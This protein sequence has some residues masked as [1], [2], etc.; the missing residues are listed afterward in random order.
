MLCFFAVFILSAE[1]TDKGLNVAIK[2]FFSER[3]VQF[4]RYQQIEKY[5]YFC[6]CVYFNTFLN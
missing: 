5:F 3:N 4:V 2:Y 1:I 6:S